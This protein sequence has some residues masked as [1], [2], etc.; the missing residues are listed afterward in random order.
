M[1][2]HGGRR[3]SR[4]SPG[5]RASG[6]AARAVGSV[7]DGTA[8]AGG[9]AGGMSGGGNRSIKGRRR[10]CGAG[11]AGDNESIGNTGGNG[12]AL[13]AGT[14]RAAGRGPAVAGGRGALPTRGVSATTPLS[15]SER[16]SPV[17]LSARWSSSLSPRSRSARLARK[18]GS[19]ASERLGTSS[20][21]TGLKLYR[22]SGRQ[23]CNSAL[24]TYLRVTRN[25]TSC[26]ISAHTRCN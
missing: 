26:S 9:G 4:T 16:L 18:S 12:G 6:D 20:P 19:S 13:E 1:A 22:G 15:R 11:G 7:C 21:A 3:T 23:L 17:T 24:Q 8:G 5:P 10:S 25:G 2:A 14:P